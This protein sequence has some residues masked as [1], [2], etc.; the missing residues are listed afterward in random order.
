M[1]TLQMTL[2]IERRLEELLQIVDKLPISVIEAAEKQRDRY[3]RQLQRKIILKHQEEMQAERQRRTMEKALLA[4][5]ILSG[6]K[7][8]FRSVPRP[9]VQRKVEKT[10]WRERVDEEMDY[11]YN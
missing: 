6:R 1:N 3:R 10:K 7:L 11:F 2:A 8:M 5:K 4:S 9:V